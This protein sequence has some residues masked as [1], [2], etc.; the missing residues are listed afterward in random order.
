MDLEPL[1]QTLSKITDGRVLSEYL[2]M[3]EGDLKKAQ[4]PVAKRNPHDKKDTALRRFMKD[5]L[6]QRVKDVG[7]DCRW[8]DLPPGTAF[9][10]RDGG[11]H[12]VCG[13][14]TLTWWPRPPMPAFEEMKE[15]HRERDRR[16]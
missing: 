11:E 4:I 10:D 3:E 9:F 1:T 8:E 6:R 14:L 2:Y 7:V 15:R 16:G 5:W 12:L 13:A